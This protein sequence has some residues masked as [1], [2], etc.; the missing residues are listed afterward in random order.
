ML[1]KYFMFH[2]DV[3]IQRTSED[4]I[5]FVASMAVEIPK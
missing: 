5:N 1:Y 3:S 4:F 2:A